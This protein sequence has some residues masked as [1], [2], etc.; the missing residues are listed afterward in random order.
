VLLLRLFFDPFLSEAISYVRW[1]NLDNYFGHTVGY[2]ENLRLKY[3]TAPWQR[4]QHPW[5][6]FREVLNYLHLKLFISRKHLSNTLPKVEIIVP[7]IG[8]AMPLHGY[9]ERHRKRG[10]VPPAL[11]AEVRQLE[12]MWLA[13]LDGLSLR[14]PLSPCSWCGRGHTEDDAAPP[15]LQ[16]CVCLLVWHPDCVRAAALRGY[17]AVDLPTVE[18]PPLWRQEREDGIRLVCDLCWESM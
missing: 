8:Q 6:H 2:D 3:S 4:R 5:V 18:V 14:R 15:V 9:R 12:R 17:L 11:P 16:C 7:D 10:D 1:I 13:A